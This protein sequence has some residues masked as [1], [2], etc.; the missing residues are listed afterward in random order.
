MKTMI[1]LAT[2]ILSIV[3]G[4]GV[5]HAAFGWQSILAPCVPTSVDLSSSEVAVTCPNDRSVYIQKR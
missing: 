5:A 4:A 3:L 2:L 1:V